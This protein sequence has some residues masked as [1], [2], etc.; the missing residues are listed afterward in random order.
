MVVAV[1]VAEG[2]VLD[3]GVVVKVVCITEVDW[4]LKLDHGG[5]DGFSGSFKR[6]SG[7]AGFL[8]RHWSEMNE[9]R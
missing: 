7:W 2:V 1:A 3:L 6:E 5:G 9:T 8:G 4:R